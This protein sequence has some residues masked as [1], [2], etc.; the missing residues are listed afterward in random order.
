VPG[1]K[2]PLSQFDKHRLL[3]L[4]SIRERSRIPAA[5]EKDAEKIRRR[6]LGKSPITLSDRA[7]RYFA[8][9]IKSLLG[10]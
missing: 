6:V 2:P 5:V 3:A 9:A 4:Q 8:Q 7:A 10:S 1:K